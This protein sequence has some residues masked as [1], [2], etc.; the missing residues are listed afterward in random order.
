MSSKNLTISGVLALLLSV[1]SLILA[2]G[3][4][5]VVVEFVKD[6]PLVLSFDAQ[7]IASI[8][9]KG[10]DGLVQLRKQGE[11]F[12]VSS[13]LG[14]PASMGKINGGLID[15]CYRIRCAAE[16]SKSADTH[17]DLGVGGGDESTTLS[18]KDAQGKEIL[19]VI[20]GKFLDDQRGNYVRL[21]TEDTVY[22]SS[23]PVSFSSD[24]L[25]YLDKDILKTERND[26]ARVDVLGPE[27]SYS[28]L[29][30][31]NGRPELQGVPQ[32][33][34]ANGEV[35]A[36][37]GASGYL[38][39]ENFFPAEEKKDLKFDTTYKLEMS[40][41]PTYVLHVAKV[42][43][44]FYVKCEAEWRGPD[45]KSITTLKQ[46]EKLSEEEMQERSDYIESMNAMEAFS[47]KHQ[48]WVYEV[49]S[50]LG[51][52]LTK[53]FADLVDEKAE[54]E[55]QVQASHILI[56]FEG[57]EA[58]P[59]AG[60]ELLSKDAAQTKIEELLKLVQEKPDI[61]ADLAKEHSSCPSAA[62]GGDLGSF[63]FETMAKPFSEAAFKLE[64]DETSGVVETIFGY[65]II[66][67]T[68]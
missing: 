12:V 68:K 13:K 52:N 44:K 22:L 48:S 3:P 51:G 18:F 26:V 60:K 21:S 6:R 64:V 14:Y 34:Q 41:Q 63:D 11:G 16:I 17:S 56:P 61:F 42:E 54:E 45:P 23:Q 19:G 67:R 55:R 33:K 35:G 27:G 24:N 59:A 53:K 39:F 62:K 37:L 50:W 28:I 5:E 38:S 25:N 20:A 15:A 57:S 32:G 7:S 9:V 49:S 58:K 2:L 43:D 46:D 40:M 29:N 30:S 4:G 8:D 36:V 66:K 1:W 65:H 31:E 10:R 47:V